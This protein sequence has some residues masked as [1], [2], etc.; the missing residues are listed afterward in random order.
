MNTSE[1][2]TQMTSTRSSEAILSLTAE[3]STRDDASVCK[4]K[5]DP[6]L[7]KE[8]E[9][10]AMKKQKVFQSS[11]DV[12]AKEI[13]HGGRHYLDTTHSTN[14]VANQSILKQNSATILANEVGRS[15][16]DLLT[17]FEVM[18]R[19]VIHSL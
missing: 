16:A 3:N 11:M 14:V 12:E 13:G 10:V 9:Q 2:S 5:A 7:G 4:R 6:R 8:A 19:L 18:Q 1:S 15:T 17:S